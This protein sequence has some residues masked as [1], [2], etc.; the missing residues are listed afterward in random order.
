MIILARDDVFP[1]AVRDNVAYVIVAI[2]MIVFGLLVVRQLYMTIHKIV[3][4]C[5]AKKSSHSDDENERADFNQVESPARAQHPKSTHQ[6]DLERGQGRPQAALENAGSRPGANGSMRDGPNASLQS[7]QNTH[8]LGGSMRAD[9]SRSAPNGH[10]Q[11]GASMRSGLDEYGRPLP[12]QPTP[13][14]SL[15][16]GQSSLPGA[17]HDPGNLRTN[18]TSSLPGSN[19]APSITPPGSLRTAP[20]SGGNF[21]GPTQGGVT[22]GGAAIGVAAATSRRR[23]K[24]LAPKRGSLPPPWSG[25]AY[26]EPNTAVVM[27]EYDLDKELNLRD[28]D[29]GKQHLNASF[30]SSSDS[31]DRASSGYGYSGKLSFASVSDQPFSRAMASPPPLLERDSHSVSSTSSSRE[32]SSRLDALAAKYLVEDLSHK[33]SPVDM[34]DAKVSMVGSLPLKESLAFIPRPLVASKSLGLEHT[35]TTTTDTDDQTTKR[36]THSHNGVY[37]RSRDDEFDERDRRSIDS[38]EDE[39]EL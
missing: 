2:N 8:Q 5:K 25:D 19:R 16:S 14:G 31:Y 26:A 36:R 6:S 13:P 21:R 15:R 23:E 34:N 1:Q 32:A 3:R 30:A 9:P 37:R 18:P 24:E 39:I 33:K 28:D 20:S 27:P 12:N 35:S 17:A 22:S 10:L 11:G 38:S 29:D 7:G 4:N